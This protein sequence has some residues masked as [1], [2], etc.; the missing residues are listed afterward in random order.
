MA[1][2]RFATADGD[3]GAVGEVDDSV[4]T[5][6]MNAGKGF[7]AGWEALQKGSEGRKVFADEIP[8]ERRDSNGPQDVF[9][10]L[11]YVHGIVERRMF[12]G[13]WSVGA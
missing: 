11:P 5:G 8:P 13:S 3:N 4:V 1:S 12:M 10:G 2:L 9:E 7:G 6:A